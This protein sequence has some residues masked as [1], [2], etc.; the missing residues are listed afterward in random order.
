MIG[1]IPIHVVLKCDEQGVRNERHLVV[2]GYRGV[3]SNNLFSS[4]D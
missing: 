3:M 2:F 1:H 4:S